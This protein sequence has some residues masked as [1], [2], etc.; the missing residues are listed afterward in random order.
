MAGIR[1]TVR[2]SHTEGQDFGTGTTATPTNEV[3]EAREE[4]GV[5]EKDHAA[6][7]NPHLENGIAGD[8][9]P[10][11]RDYLMSRHGTIDLNP[12]PT[13]DPA[14]PLNW[15]SWK[16]YHLA[17]S[18]TFCIDRSI[19]IRGVPKDLESQNRLNCSKLIFSEKCQPFPCCFSRN[20][21]HFHSS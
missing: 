10:E 16:V 17:V 3:F 1:D 9:S 2:E 13:M 11:H 6:M 12:L 18:F 19:S 20:D 15:P 8:L 14:D 7:D 5:A 4:N 21:D